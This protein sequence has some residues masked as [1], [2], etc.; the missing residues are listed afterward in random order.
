MA[1]GDASDLRQ[2]LSDELHAW[3]LYDFAGASRF[4]SYVYPVGND[5][6]DSSLAL[7][8]FRS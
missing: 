2:R 7:P 3:V 5:D 4:I 1:F 8:V 6:R